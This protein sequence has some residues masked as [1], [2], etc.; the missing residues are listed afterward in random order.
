MLGDAVRDTIVARQQNARLASMIVPEY[1]NEEGLL[2]DNGHNM[3]R[4]MPSRERE[5]KDLVPDALALSSDVYC[6]NNNTAKAYHTQSFYSTNNGWVWLSD[7]FKYQTSFMEI[8]SKV[9]DF[10]RAI[11]D[12]PYIDAETGLVSGI[13]FQYVNA[14][15]I[16]IAYVTKGTT[17]LSDWVENIKQGLSGNS[18]LYKRASDNA[19][20]INKKLKDYIGDS[21]YLY[22][23]GH[24]LGGGMA[25][26][27]AMKE[28]RPS[29]TFN[30]ASVHPDIVMNNMANYSN[31]VKN[32]AMIGIYVEGE[33]LSSSMSDTVGLP[34]NGNRYKI[35]ISSKYLTS[36]GMIERHLLEP[37]CSQYG[38]HRMSWNNRIFVKI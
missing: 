4:N 35:V 2:S 11:R 36:G 17:S 18:P 20:L 5:N 33:A 24:S 9:R 30:A 8:S 22:F 13:F 19:R 23:F 27:N 38:L 7:Y 28:N 31:L 12:L 16:R 37:L 29:I 21:G 15:I 6:L 25:N 26:Y 34:K 1:N 10:L 14:K 32:K 3:L